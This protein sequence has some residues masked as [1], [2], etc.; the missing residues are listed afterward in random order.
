MNIPKKAAPLLPG[1]AEHDGPLFFVIAIIVFLA[2][3]AAI[4]GQLAIQNVAQWKQAVKSEMTVQILSGNSNEARRAVVVLEKQA[5]VKTARLGTRD[6]AKALLEPW[7][8]ADNIPD[9]LPIPLLIYVKLSGKNPPN[10]AFLHSQLADD[11][12]DASIDDHQHWARDL[13]RSARAVQILSLAVLSLLVTASIAITGFATRSG[14]AARRDLVNVL[15][16]VGAKDR[17]IARLFGRRF[18]MLGV[19]AGALGALLA[20]ISVGVLWLSGAAQTGL[21]SHI[22]R[23]GFGHILLLVPVPLI[24]AL[25]GGW[26]AYA[27]VMRALRKQN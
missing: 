17:V 6:E 21:S 5:G 11:A 13:A 14:L 12:I 1:D 22:A 18:V 2:S 23:L 16:R 7:L 27:S 26:T 25:V 8:G 19:K 4:S 9:D 10:A 15:H 24:T 20:A 3:L